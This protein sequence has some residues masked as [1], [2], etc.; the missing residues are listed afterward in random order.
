MDAAS[1]I[2][3]WAMERARDRV[4]VAAHRRLMASECAADKRMC[5]VYAELAPEVAVESRQMS[6]DEERATQAPKSQKS[7]KA[8]KSP[9]SPKSPKPKKRRKQT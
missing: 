4:V 9:K 6:D 5:A 3:A 2:S 1:T 8:P 7:Q